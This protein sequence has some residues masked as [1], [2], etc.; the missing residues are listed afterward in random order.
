M[1]WHIEY[2]GNGVQIYHRQRLLLLENGR[3]FDIEFW[4]RHIVKPNTI[5]TGKWN[6]NEKLV[7]EIQ[8]NSRLWW[9]C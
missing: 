1:I 8:N 3:S 9:S 7:T 6:P 5:K 4:I 2:G